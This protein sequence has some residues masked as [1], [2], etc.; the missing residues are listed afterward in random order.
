MHIL[1]RVLRE[2][3]V[4]VLLGLLFVIPKTAA[5]AEEAKPA[6][7]TPTLEQRVAGL[8]AYIANSD[9]SA[10]LKDAKGNIPDGL[11]TPSVGFR[12]PATTP[13]R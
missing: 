5:S 13:G 9:P 1:P 7:P 2:P 12:G 10:S 3:A 11:T 4:C 6:A 8:E